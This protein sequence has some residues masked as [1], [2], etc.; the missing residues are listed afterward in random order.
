M[1]QHGI[2]IVNQPVVYIFNYHKENLLTRM[3]MSVAFGIPIRRVGTLKL[4][5]VRYFETSGNSN[6]STQRINLEHPNYHPR[7]CMKIWRRITTVAIEAYLWIENLPFMNSA[8]LKH[9][10]ML[11]Q[12]KLI[13]LKTV[14][15]LITEKLLAF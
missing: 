11:G 14:I 8:A 9:E 4:K 13:A 5:T 12:P 10:I 7:I 15:C 3:R 6:P 1:D 2:G